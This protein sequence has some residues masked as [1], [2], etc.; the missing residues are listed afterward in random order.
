[1]EACPWS[2][3]FGYRFLRKSGGVRTRVATMRAILAA[4]T[5]A[6]RSHLTKSV[7]S[8]M[9]CGSLALRHHPC[10]D[11]SRDPSFGRKVALALA[12]LPRRPRP[13]ALAI[14]IDLGFCARRTLLGELEADA[15]ARALRAARPGRPGEELQVT[16]VAP[17]EAGPDRPEAAPAA[18]VLE[19][20]LAVVSILVC[21]VDDHGIPGYPLLSMQAL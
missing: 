19:H 9:L 16:A 2:E 7:Q 4:T 13:R 3:H 6:A 17:V 11:H 5:R 8:V 15:V 18:D 1:M 14:A 12:A 10:D 20:H 21:P